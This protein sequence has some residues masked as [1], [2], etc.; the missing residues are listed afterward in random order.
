VTPGWVAEKS[1]LGLI[2]KMQEPGRLGLLGA[3][4]MLWESNAASTDPGSNQAGSDLTAATPAGDLARAGWPLSK[5][6]VPYIPPPPHPSIS[7]SQWLDLARMGIPNIVDYFTK[8]APPPAPLPSTPGKIPAADANPYAPGAIGEAANLAT[9]LLSGGAGSAEL[10]AGRLVP[11]LE[12]GGKSLL[13]TAQ[14][15]ITDAAAA[16]AKE[17]AALTERATQVHGALEEIAGRLRTTA[18]LSTDG[19]TIIGGGRRDL[20][21]VQKALIQPGEIAAKL[22]GAHAEITVLAKAKKE[23]LTP[24]TLVSTRRICDQCRSAIDDADGVLIDKHT[25]VFPGRGNN[26]NSALR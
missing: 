8:P 20:D 1:L 18:I 3:L 13:D 5:S 16:R 22:P 24:R 4:P 19:K 15:R 26:V 21:P 12:I 2:G 17:I 7:A 6:G 9:L 23:G 10:I 25:A 11:E 14:A